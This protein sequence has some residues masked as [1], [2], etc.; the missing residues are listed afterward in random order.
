MS[1]KML[2]TKEVSPGEYSDLHG[3]LMDELKM[4]KRK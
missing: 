2:M 3:F 4:F 1:N